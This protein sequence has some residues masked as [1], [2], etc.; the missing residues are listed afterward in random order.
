MRH[1]RITGEH[2]QLMVNEI[3]VVIV[4]LEAV[5]LQTM[6]LQVAPC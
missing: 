3:V 4:A 5:T 6:L 1:N 2:A